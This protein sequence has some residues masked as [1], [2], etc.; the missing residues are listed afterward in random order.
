[1][2]GAQISFNLIVMSKIKSRFQVRA[3]ETSSPMIHRM[4]L[5]VNGRLQR[6]A[7]KLQDR[8]E[9]L[10]VTTKKCLFFGGA[11]LLIAWRSISSR[12]GRSAVSVQ[13]IVPCPLS[14]GSDGLRPL[15]PSGGV[16]R[17]EYKMVRSFHHYLDSLGS[18]P[19]GTVVRD[20]I[21]H[22]RPGILD[23]IKIIE[24][25]YLEK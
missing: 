16:S 20:S 14:G 12:S 19:A 23:S 11:S 21:L 24:R 25:M 4:S 7:K 6:L 22:E 1:M 5:A 8:S 17:R 2:S 15:S 9:R 13:S 3:E 10:S 18:T